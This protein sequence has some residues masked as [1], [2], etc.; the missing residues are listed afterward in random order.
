MPSFLR[1]THIVQ[2]AHQRVKMI[3]R[4]IKIFIGGGRGGAGAVDGGE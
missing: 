2:T 3:K 4:T 1:L